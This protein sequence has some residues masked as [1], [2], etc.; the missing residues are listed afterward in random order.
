MFLRGCISWTCGDGEFK[1]RNWET[2]KFNKA[3]KLME[4]EA[5]YIGYQLQ[6]CL[7]AYTWDS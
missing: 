6:T 5:A 7:V 3:K 4:Y 1:Q 2:E